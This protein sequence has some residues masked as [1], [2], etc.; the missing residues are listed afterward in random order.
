MRPPTRTV[1]TLEGALKRIKVNRRLAILS[2]VDYKSH[3]PRQLAPLLSERE[4]GKLNCFIIGLEV[5]PIYRN[6]SS[7][8]IY[9]LALRRMHFGVSNALKKAAFTFTNRQTNMN[10]KHFQAL[11]KRALVKSVWEIDRQLAEIDNAFNFLLLVTP[12]NT[13]QAWSSFKK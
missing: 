4:A 12:V 8:E 11:G 10:L 2:V 1:E 5:R 13:D 9:P 7:N 3:I 6:P